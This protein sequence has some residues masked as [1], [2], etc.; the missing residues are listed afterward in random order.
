MLNK[1]DLSRVDLNLLTLFEVVLEGR[2]AGRAAAR[3]H[4]TPSAISH[5][6]GRLR[7]LLNDPLFIRHPRGLNPTERALALAAPVAEVLERARDV[8]AGAEAFDPRSSQRRFVIG[9]VDGIGTIVL[10]GLMSAITRMSSGVTICVRSIFPMGVVDALDQRTVDLALTPLTPFRMLPPRFSARALYHDDF[11]IA[12]RVGHPL[13]ER[14]TLENYCAATHLLVGQ[15]DGPGFV[16]RVLAERG[17]SRRVQ[18]TVPSFMYGL[19]VLAETDIVAAMPRH[20]IARHGPRAG[21]ASADPPIPLSQDVL[22]IMTAK[23]ATVDPGIAW[24]A[25]RVVEA[26]APYIL[27]PASRDASSTLDDLS[28]R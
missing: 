2:H 1:I 18:L 11:V 13:L 28:P 25:D 9:A 10:P 8:I 12:A 3:L 6:L 16:D 22:G 27:D 14:P 4:L 7:R 23:A 24:L 15:G 26:F 19:A 21:V 5:G 17:L 20:F